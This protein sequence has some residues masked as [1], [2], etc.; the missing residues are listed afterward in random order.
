MTSILQCPVCREPLLPTATGYQCA[1]NHSFDAARQGYV[2]LVLAH[3]KHSKEPGDDPDM[4]QSRRRFLD[5][6]YYLKVSDGI[7]RTIATALSSLVPHTNCS[8]LDAGCG[9]GFYLQRLKEA[10]AHGSAAHLPI[11]Y[12]GVDVSKFAVRQATQRDRTMAWFV[13]SINDLPFLDGS[14]DIVLSVFSPA[15]ILEF[16]RI[17]KQSGSL[18]FISPGPRH[19]N[20]LREIIYPVTREHA[21]PA[22]TEKAEALFAPATVARITYPLALVSNQEIM[23]LLAMTPYYWNIDRE[24]KAKVAALDRLQLDVD[25]EIRVFKKKSGDGP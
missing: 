20:G 12:H 9:E 6:G 21:A 5:L 18:I 1:T 25:V 13:A 3:N 22:I 24:T 10:L 14:L 16:A 15:N 19:L 4:I 7:N 23:D 8:I 2:N 11:E 17:L